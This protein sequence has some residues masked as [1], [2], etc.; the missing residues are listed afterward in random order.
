MF[1]VTGDQLAARRRAAVVVAT[2]CS[3]LLAR[4][5]RRDPVEV[6]DPDERDRISSPRLG[7]RLPRRRPAAGRSTS[8]LVHGHC[9]SGSTEHGGADQPAVGA[10]SGGRLHAHPLPRHHGPAAGAPRCRRGRR[11]CSA[12]SASSGAPCASCAT[13]RRRCSSW[14]PTCST[15]TA[16]RPSST[17]PSVY[18][19]QAS[20]ASR[21]TTLI[22]TILIV[23]FVAVRRRAALRPVAQRHRRPPHDPGPA[24]SSGSW[25]SPSAS[26]CRRSSSLPFLGLAAAIGLVLGGT[27]ALSRSFFSQLIPPRTRGA[28]TSASTR[29]SSAARRWLGTPRVRPRVHQPTG[30]YRPASS[31]CWSSSSSV[32]CC[33]RVDAARGIAEAGQP[34]PARLSG[35][36]DRVG[37]RP[38][39][40]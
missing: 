21:P 38:D 8:S 28:S 13:T 22:A 14:S 4:R 16:S 31:R 26:S 27:Q 6:A 37:P 36:S 30:S 29:P 7:L 32:P 11:W 35:P 18:G 17:P 3:G 19:E 34:V 12:A 10:R 9:R 1:F 23:Q 5:L 33:W 24:W 15:T 2:S 20:S 25:S 40:V 39:R